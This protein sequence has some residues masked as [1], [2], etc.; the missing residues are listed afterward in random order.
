M[1]MSLLCALL[2]SA[3]VWL[4]LAR[5]WLNIIL[6]FALLGH[7]ANLFIFTIGGL[8]PGKAPIISEHLDTLTGPVADPVP[9]ALILTAIVIGFGMQAF[10]LLLF[11]LASRKKGGS[12]DELSE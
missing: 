9:Q 2:I 10:L 8:L 7:G 12:T 11:S 1:M 4:L 6:G 5:G 3:G